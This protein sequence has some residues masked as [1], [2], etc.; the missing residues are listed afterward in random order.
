MGLYVEIGFLDTEKLLD[1][2]MQDKIFSYK[3]KY[4]ESQ[5]KA[6]SS[7]YRLGNSF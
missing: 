4:F 7:L 3:K 6:H 2:I 1:I 5:D